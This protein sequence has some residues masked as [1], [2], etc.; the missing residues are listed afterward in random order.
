MRPIAQRLRALDEAL[1]SLPIPFPRTS[2]W[3][4]ETLERFYEV[5][6]RQ[7]VLRVGR[8]GGKSSTLCRVAV[9]EA[10]YGEH[11]IPPGDLGVVAIISVSR[12][13][14]NQRLRTIKAILDALGV[15]YRPIDGGIELEGKPVAFKVF[16]ASIAGVSGFT[17]ICVLCDEV[18]KWRDADTGAN[19]AR[20]VLASLR[21]TMATQRSA[22]IFLSSSPLG[23]L[24]AH[25]NAFDE[26]DNA[27]QLAA[28]APTWVANPS[29]SEADTHALERDE[30]RWRREYGAV[31]MEGDE[32]SLLSA[33]LLDRATRTEEGDV[34]REPGVSYVAAMDPGFVRNPWT[35]VIA[36]KR[37]VGGRI[38]RSIVVARE[39]RGTSD[40]PNDPAQ[41]LGQIALL[42]RAYGVEVVESDQYERFGLSS[43][44]ERPEIGLYIRVCE[45]SATERLARYEALVTQAS[46]GEIDLPPLKQL[47]ATCLPFGRS[48][49]PTGLRFTC[50]R[51]RTGGTRTTPRASRLR[52]H[53]ALLSRREH[54]NPSLRA[55]RGCWR[56][57]S[58]SKKS[59][60]ASQRK[61]LALASFSTSRLR[62]A[63][64]GSHG[65]GRTTVRDWRRFGI[66][67]RRRL[68][69]RNCPTPHRAA[70]RGEAIAP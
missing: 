29:I 54:P 27:M 67:D 31:P 36:G 34:P 22:R 13:E 63:H 52:S 61:V 26:G 7:L 46:D 40:K 16:A 50:P 32:A 35:F 15:K 8:R 38:K 2:P 59:A 20:E 44:A 28:F 9:C 30:D 10:L 55:R 60:S 5:G 39:W 65:D 41:V 1:A 4:R 58:A 57:C 37:W 6:R 23:R 21:P 56:T 69:L 19:P 25:A 51:R 18:A 33:A 43:I 64:G 17:T 42:C 62:A 70:A 47:R 49:R 11:K 12:D 66:L 53:I 14:A 48:S 3:W 45:R 68:T 24:D